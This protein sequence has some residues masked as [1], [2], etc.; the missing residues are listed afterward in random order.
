MKTWGN[1]KEKTYE[2]LYNNNNE[3]VVCNFS[4]V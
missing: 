4:Y 2:Q 1:L 3:I